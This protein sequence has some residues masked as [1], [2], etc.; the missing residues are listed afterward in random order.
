MIR[1]DSASIYNRIVDKLQQDPDWKV[2]VNNDVVAAMIKSNAEANAETARYAEYLFKE[3]RWDTAQNKSSILSMANMMGYQPK[4]KISARGS[5]YV[6]LS[7]QIHNVGKGTISY[8]SFLQLKDKVKTNAT[9]GFSPNAGGSISL[10]SSTTV[11]C[12]NKNFIITKSNSLNV[13]DYITSVDIMEGTKETIYIDIDTL[14]ST[15]TTSRLDPYLYI[16]V[17]IYD[18]EDA[19]NLS[20]IPFLSVL[21]AYKN[22]S[23]ETDGVD[24][25]PYRIV[26]SLLLSNPSDKDCELYN[27]LYSQNLFYLK[28]KNDLYNNNYLDLSKDS[29]IDHIEI[30]YVKT[31]GSQGNINDLFSNFT[32]SAKDDNGT[33]YRL[34]GINYT[35][36][37]GGVDEE[38]INDIK[39]NT[40]KSYTKYFGIGTKEAYEKAIS[41]TEFT[42]NGIVGS[43]VPKKVHVF[44]DYYTNNAGDRQLVTYVSFIGSGLEDL[45]Y[46]PS[47][48]NPYEPI[49]N[50]LNYYLVRLKSPQDI[51]KFVP[52]EY[53]SFSVGMDCSVDNSTEYELVGLQTAISNYVD[54]LWG[55]NSDSID[56]GNS[57]SVSTLQTAIMN[58]FTDVVVENVTVEAVTRLKWN[59]AVLISPKSDESGVI[60]TC[61]IPFSFSSVFLGDLSTTPGFVDHRSGGQYVMRIDIMYKKPKFYGGIDSSFHKSIFVKEDS[62]RS[63]D[64]TGFYAIQTVN[65]IVWLDNGLSDISQIESNDYTELGTVDKLDFCYQIDYESKVFSNSDFTALENDIKLQK[66]ATRSSS[67][68]YG[69]LDDYIIYFSGSYNQNA[70]KIGYGWFEFTFDDIY[71]TLTYFSNYDASLRNELNRCQL[72]ALKCGVS[73]DQ[74]FKIFKELASKYVDIY[75]SMRPVKPNLN[76]SSASGLSNY[77]PNRSNEVLYIDSYD[78]P[79]LDNLNNTSN[80]TVDK[81]SRFINVNCSYKD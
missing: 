8:D 74:V 14:R 10:N 57:F 46:N 20:S 80:L 68:S 51:I 41:N 36:I 49:E 1:F 9:A 61:R 11:T 54:S 55:P 64:R 35:P 79:I 25:V 34:Y 37:N 63:I 28:F 30:H 56:F 81:K 23:N 52:P 70:N 76:L 24:Y 22:P 17:T 32:L 38:E 21:V 73:N 47:E 29:S 60:H 3:S 18:C 45:G 65:P 69:A 72:H 2:I 5:I 13:G 42:V 78:T 15:A 75:V 77:G 19:S 53:V 48:E 12:G 4:R 39:R 33:S 50:A 27:D 67:N 7:S 6:S 58:K 43:I 44:G 40:I 62:N 71:N 26:E 59:D 66:K 31:S 16:P